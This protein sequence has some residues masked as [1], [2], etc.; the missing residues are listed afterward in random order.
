[1]KGFLRII[2]VVAASLILLSVFPLFFSNSSVSG[3]NN[4][5]IRAEALD[6][7]ASLTLNGSVE[8]YVQN[9]DVGAINS[10]VSG[11]LP[12]TDD[13]SIEINGIVNPVIFISCICSQAQ[14]E[15]LENILSPLE[16]GYRQRN[17]S[18]RIKRAAFGSIDSR[19]NIIFVFGYTDMNSQK[20][21]LENF[22]SNGGTVFLFGDLNR[23]QA[24][25]GI[26]NGIFG[27]GWDDTLTASADA[28]FDDPENPSRVSHRI[29]TYYANISGGA[30]DD[31]FNGFNRAGNIN[32]ILKDERSVIS[33]NPGSAAKK[34]SLVKVNSF[35]EKNG[36]GRTVWF[37][38]YDYT[39]DMQ[40][41]K[42]LT[43][44]AVMWASGESYSMDRFQKKLA[45]KY[46]KARYIGVLDGFEPFEISLI[47]WRVFY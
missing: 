2:E 36:R 46:I 41:M 24:E 45:E 34:I 8:A 39:G 26:M 14:T 38:G 47:V 28:K 44:A 7:L 4:A 9:N 17:I 3:W 22:L 35:V 33:D 37:A 12:K 29:G 11:L 27:L 21:F 23:A 19:T 16:S 13:Y 25:D 6:I 1:M 40:Q 42:N 32:K 18:V 20:V 10:A 31:R 30:F 5:V 43:K 15:D